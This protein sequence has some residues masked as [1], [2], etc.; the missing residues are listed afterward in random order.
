MCDLSDARIIEAYNSIVEEDTANWLLLG[1]NDTRDV[2]SLYSSGSGGLSEFR[3][4]LKDEVLYGFVKVEDRNIL[5][6]WVSEHV[7]GVRRAR[8]LVHSRSVAS[9]LKLHHAQ[10]TASNLTDLSDTNIRTRLKLGEQQLSARKSSSSLDNKQK[11]ISRQ[12]SGIPLP[13]SPIQRKPSVDD[14]FVEASETLPNEED[15]DNA[16]VEIDD[17]TLMKRQEEDQKRREQEAQEEAAKKREQDEKRA[18]AL[19]KQEEERKAEAERQRLAVEKEK[20]RQRLAA[21]KEAERKRQLAEQERARKAEEER[22]K[23]ETEEKRQLEEKKRLQQRLLEAEKNKDILLSG[24]ISVQ[25]NGSPVISLIIQLKS[26]K[27]TK[28]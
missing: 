27:L 24:F 15:P 14:D 11:R 8:A 16:K 5:I 17:T 20:E 1:Y 9:L 12:N 21:E 13:Q 6:T 4:Q 3:N 23:K 7:S 18:A 26:K 25:P 28:N 10:V 2:I 19:R 22:L